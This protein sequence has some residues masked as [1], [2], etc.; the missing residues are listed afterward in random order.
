MELDKELFQS[1]TGSGAMRFDTAGDERRRSSRVPVSLRGTLIPMND[2]S[3]GK[4]VQVKLREMSLTGLSLVV[5]GETSVTGEIPVTA[6]FV[7]ILPLRNGGQVRLLYE[8]VRHQQQ[9]G[10]TVIGARLL[11]QL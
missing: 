9:Q 1:L 11:R 6:L 5:T 7:M 3:V 10:A 8:R 4:P 2:G